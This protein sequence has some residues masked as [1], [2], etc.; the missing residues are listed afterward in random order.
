MIVGGRAANSYNFV[1]RPNTVND[2]RMRLLKCG[3]TAGTCVRQMKTSEKNEFEGWPTPSEQRAARE[4][5]VPQL[6]GG[7][8][9]YSIAS[10]AIRRVGRAGNP[11]ELA[12]LLRSLRTPLVDLRAA[13]RRSNADRQQVA[14][15]YSGET[16][17]AY[18]A[19]YLNPYVDLARW[20]LKRSLDPAPIG[21]LLRVG[22][23]GPGPCPEVVALL[24]LLNAVDSHCRGIDL[25]LFDVNHE[26]WRPVRKAV[27]E[28]GLSLFPCIPVS[29]TEIT[30]RIGLDEGFKAPKAELDVV[31]GQNFLNEGVASGAHLISNLG[32]IFDRLKPGGCIIIADQQN[33]SAKNGL[34]RIEGWNPMGSSTKVWKN[35]EIKS[36]PPD[37]EVTPGFKELFVAQ[38]LLPPRIN[39]R[40]KAVRVTKDL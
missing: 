6:E 30:V 19:G 22:I 31:I 35:T 28:A 20:C 34:K 33:E 7:P 27:I 4:R 10:D 17:L 2:L 11:A 13:Y 21:T 15:D 12:M 8:I 9:G 38:P 36:L 3:I 1:A 25:Q 29:Q 39:N 16:A 23:I 40:F 24:D 26:A 14:I 32:S 37:W 5:L 18:C